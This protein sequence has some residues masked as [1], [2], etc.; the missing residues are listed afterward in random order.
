[1]SIGPGAV[2]RLYGTYATSPECV[3]DLATMLLQEPSPTAIPCLP[4]TTQQVIDK[5]VNISLL[6][7]MIGVVGYDVS[8]NNKV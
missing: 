5:S 1:M 4:M 8:S 3:K 2:A 6:V 7:H